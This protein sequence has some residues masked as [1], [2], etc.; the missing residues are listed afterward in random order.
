M[1]SFLI[2]MRNLIFFNI[3]LVILVQ[4][5]VRDLSDRVILEKASSS[6]INNPRELRNLMRP[7]AYRRFCIDYT[8]LTLTF[9][10]LV[11]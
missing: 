2:G 1:L 8:W 10:P 4:M 11:H 3:L 6:F 9:C 7:E 5:E